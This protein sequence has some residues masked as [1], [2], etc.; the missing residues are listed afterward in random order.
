MITQLEA[1]RQTL[2]ERIHSM[3]KRMKQDGAKFYFK[4]E[5]LDYLSETD[6]LLKQVIR[7]ERN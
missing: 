7:L 1:L 6:K 5:N 3:V 2:N 4:K